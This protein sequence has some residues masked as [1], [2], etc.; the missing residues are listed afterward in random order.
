MRNEAR[1]EMTKDRYALGKT[2]GGRT[3]APP[4]ATSQMIIELLGDDPGI[5]GIQGGIE[6]GKCPLCHAHLF[7]TS[8]KCV[9]Y[10]RQILANRL[11]ILWKYTL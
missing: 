7:K 2:G 11:T 6:F 4:K 9:K 1:K 10:D 8:Q 5:S 3:P